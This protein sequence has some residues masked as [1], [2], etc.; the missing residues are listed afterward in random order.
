[1]KMTEI[2]WQ[3]WVLEVRHMEL[4]A[5]NPNPNWM[6]YLEKVHLAM[7]VRIIIGRLYISNK[8]SYS[9]CVL[10]YSNKT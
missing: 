10:Y 2:L 4:K 8:C 3:E 9:Y 1:M 6:S 7:K 5:D